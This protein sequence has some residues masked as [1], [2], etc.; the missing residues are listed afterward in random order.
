MG[1]TIEI[2]DNT[3]QGLNVSDGGHLRM[4]NVTVRNNGAGGITLS[5]ATADLDNVKILDH[6]NAPTALSIG[7]NSGVPA[8]NVMVTNNGRNGVLVDGGQVRL[9]NST[10][11][12]SQTDVS[13]AFAAH[14]DL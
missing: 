4:S 12:H 2:H 14:L 9:V 10:I 5:N 8:T 3:G 7:L 11:G 6:P 13:A 1:G